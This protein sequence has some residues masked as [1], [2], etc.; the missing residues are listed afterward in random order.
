MSGPS[1][2]RFAY[3]G[4]VLREGPGAVD[5]LAAEVAAAGAER[6]LLVTGETVGATPAVMEPV[7]TGLGDAHAGTFA[8]TTPEKR[9]STAARAARRARETEA[10]ALVAVGGGSTVDVARAAAVLAGRLRGGGDLEAVLADAGREF[11]ATGT[12]AVD[13]PPLP[14]V[15]VPTTLAGADCSQVAGLNADPAGGLVDEPVAGGLSD[16]RLT[17][18]ASVWDPDLLATTPDAVLAGSAMNGLDKGIETVYAAAATPVTDATAVHGLSTFQDALLAYGDGD[19]S[20]ATYR[21]LARGCL[22]VQY[23]VSRADAGT[24]SVLHAFG[25]AITAAGTVQ[26][27]A[28]HA[29]IAP[30]AL[31]YILEQVEDRAALLARALAP[32]TVDEDPD[33]DPVAGVV[34]AVREVVVALD[35]PTRLRDVDGPTRS[36]LEAVAEATLADSFMRNAPPALEPSVSDLQAILERAW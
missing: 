4:P 34:E 35:L 15:A 31:A 26:Q 33:L 36:E 32:E 7:R 21:E 10:G 9:F 13:A 19:R 29:V 6:A 25:H 11:A 17:P 3:D 8:G 5:G 1:T 27:G 18:A 24:L 28:A 14:V 2:T 16:P 30:A 12:L 20:A 22:L 23:G